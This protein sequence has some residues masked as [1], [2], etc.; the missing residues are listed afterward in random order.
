[1][2]VTL[3]LQYE[4]ARREDPG[5]VQTK[6][7][8]SI[9]MWSQR[10]ATSSI[11]AVAPYLHSHSKEF[12]FRWPFRSSIQA[13]ISNALSLTTWKNCGQ[14]RAHDDSRRER[15]VRIYFPYREDDSKSL[16]CMPI[17]HDMARE[18]E[19]VIRRYCRESIITKHKRYPHKALKT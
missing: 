18:N 11:E 6:H 15:W 8:N 3:A 4:Y 19:S 7:A 1:M 10:S 14:I 5:L 13:I 16:A 2:L 9:F 12:M 17:V